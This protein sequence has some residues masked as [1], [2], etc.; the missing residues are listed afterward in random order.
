[1]PL[2]KKWPIRV[3]VQTKISMFVANNT[4]NDSCKAVLIQFITKQRI[5]YWFYLAKQA[6]N[7]NDSL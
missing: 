2:I 5:I 1:M 3:I 6:V 4:I 7:K